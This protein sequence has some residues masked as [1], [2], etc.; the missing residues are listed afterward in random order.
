M[1]AIELIE[2]TKR[3]GE[4][5]AVDSLN[6]EVHSG[7]IFG[8]VGPNGSGKTT[9]IRMIAGL[10]EPSGGEARVMGISAQKSPG[11]VKRLIG[12]M[13]DYFGVYPD[14]RTWEYLDFFSACYQIEERRRSQII[15]EL[16][17]LVE[18]RH[19]RDDMVDKLSRDEAA[20]E[21]GAHSDP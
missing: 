1:F 16:L 10:L 21:F 7:D 17:E 4:R 20:P 6:L 11:G 8:F 14:L 13:P 3:Y 2:L 9:T 12:Y 15:E 5:T 19:R 18:L